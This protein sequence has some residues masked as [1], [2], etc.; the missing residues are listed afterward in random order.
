MWVL[1]GTL[2]LPTAIKAVLNLDSIRP[3]ITDLTS[4]LTTYYNS[5]NDTSPSITLSTLVTTQYNHL[6]TILTTIT[7]TLTS[8]SIWLTT[9]SNDITTILSTTTT[10]IGKK[11]KI[12]RFRT[13]YISQILLGQILRL[14]VVPTRKT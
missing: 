5:L 10:V 7:T 2:F 11:P 12:T 4:L 13:Y 3:I 1:G 6:V 9:I 14:D 8:I